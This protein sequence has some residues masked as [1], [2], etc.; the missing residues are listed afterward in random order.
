MSKSIECTLRKYEKSKST[1]R[2]NVSSTSLA[3]KCIVFLLTNSGM[4]DIRKTTQNQK[5]D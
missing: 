1:Y 4:T 2:K 3:E 5:L